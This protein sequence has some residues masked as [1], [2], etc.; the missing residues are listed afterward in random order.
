MTEALPSQR[1]RGRKVVRPRQRRRGR[2]RVNG[3]AAAAQD[4][5]V[6]GAAEPAPTRPRTPRAL[7]PPVLRAPLRVPPPLPPASLRPS[8]PRCAQQ[9]RRAALRA[10]RAAATAAQGP[11]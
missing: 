10:L 5:A 3:A 9:P 4:V 2:W 6:G 8:R 11:A 1:K 7:H